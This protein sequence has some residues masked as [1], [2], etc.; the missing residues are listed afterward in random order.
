[1]I[2]ELIE[3]PRAK[4]MR[5]IAETAEE[6]G[7]TL[8]DVVGRSRRWIVVKARHTAMRRL[9]ATFPEMS[10]MQIGALFGGRDPSTV[11]YAL[12]R[13][14]ARISRVATHCID[15]EDFDPAFIKA[16]KEAV[17]AAVKEAA[18]EFGVPVHQIMGSD[19]THET[20]KARHAAIAKVHRMYPTIRKNELAR[21]F[22]RQKCLS[23]YDMKANAVAAE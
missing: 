10:E 5:I 17:A 9:E 16:R 6:F 14:K 13:A 23:G 8:E 18:V 3:T 22:N 21:L 7:V 1:M 2:H 11:A 15:R 12:G 20:L 19:V 4:K